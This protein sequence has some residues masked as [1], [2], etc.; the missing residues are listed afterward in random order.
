YR[1]GRGV[2]GRTWG[3]G[4][5]PRSVWPVRSRCA[6]LRSRPHP[7][8]YAPEEPEV[9]DAR[10]EGLVGF[11]PGVEDGLSP[12]GTGVQCRHER[13]G[14]GRAVQCH[15]PVGD[16][17]AHAAGEG[18][19][20][21]HAA[22]LALGA[23]G[24]TECLDGVDVPGRLGTGADLG[25]LLG[26]AQFLELQR[27]VL[28]R[29]FVAALALAVEPLEDLGGDTEGAAQEASEERLDHWPPPKSLSLTVTPMSSAARAPV[30][31]TFTAVC[32]A[33]RRASRHA[34]SRS[35]RSR[36]S[37]AA[38]PFSSPRW[39]STRS[40]PRSAAQASISSR[41]S[42]QPPETVLNDEPAEEN[43]LILPPAKSVQGISC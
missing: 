24:L 35:R 25:H 23:D 26:A 14:L 40:A 1:G 12:A 30:V 39:A 3:L 38:W 11:G 16:H 7:I 13:G 34:S 27:L 15:E 17:W 42:L 21:T 43:A 6:V 10:P 41:I 19:Y 8:E 5:I 2:A 22:L 33:V 20:P 36:M 18:I 28:H 31:S 32:Q 29:Q 37:R 9:E 4:E